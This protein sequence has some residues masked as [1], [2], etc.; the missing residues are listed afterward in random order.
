M[1]DN[2]I[3][4]ICEVCGDKAIGR[5]FT[6][7]TCEPCKA[8]FRRTGLKNKP[9]ICPSNGKCIINSLTRKICQK[10][11]L[12]KCLTVGMKKEFIR[13]GEENELKKQMLRENKLKRKLHKE[14]T[15]CMTSPDTNSTNDTD[16]GNEVLSDLLE[17]SVNIN[18]NSV[19]DQS[20]GIENVITINTNVKNGSL[21]SDIISRSQRIYS[22]VPMYKELT[23]YNGMNELERNRIREIMSASNVCNYQLSQKRH[24]IN[25]R[26]EFCKKS[27]NINE[28][29]IKDMITF[30][31]N[32][33]GFKTICTEDQISLFKYGYNELAID[34]GETGLIS[35]DVWDYGRNYG[36]V[37]CETCKAFFRRV[38]TKDYRHLDCHLNGKCIITTKTR[39]CC[40]K[41]R[42]DKCFAVGMKL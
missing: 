16:F 11:R 26:E 35:E 42:L 32:L 41:C 29:L 24:L 17:K 9:L 3:V 19:S 6:A 13:N 28:S 14:R 39:K 15:N 1:S 7:I 38:V 40:Q 2:K 27:T 22:L 33:S 30:T 12:E 21:L 23:D 31:K 10:C 25:T 36:A 34:N 37:T 20:M 4:K 8:F 18:D 5:N